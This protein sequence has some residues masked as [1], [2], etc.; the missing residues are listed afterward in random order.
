MTQFYTD[1]FNERLDEIVNEFGPKAV[2]E[3]T[4]SSYTAV[5]AWR[6][7]AIPNGKRLQALCV[8][9]GINPTWL[10]MGLGEKFLGEGD[11]GAIPNSD[12]RYVLVPKHDIRKSTNYDV[13]PY[14]S[15]T[16][17]DWLPFQ[18][19]WVE[20]IGRDPSK[21]AVIKIEKT[22]MWPEI[23]SGDTILVDISEGGQTVTEGVTSLLVNS[24]GHI[25]VRSFIIGHDDRLYYHSTDQSQHDSMRGKPFDRKETRVIGQIIQLS[26]TLI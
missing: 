17:I 18:T 19:R 10:L 24:K 15:E 7:T 21:L 1:N 2:I 5:K 6:E 26:R 11:G 16:V 9:F 20:W 8:H 4:K 12:H 22:L 23:H 14:T 25:F 13:F 3:A